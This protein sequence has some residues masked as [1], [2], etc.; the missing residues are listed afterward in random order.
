MTKLFVV[1]VHG[2]NTPEY[3]MY[4]TDVKTGLERGFKAAGA[5]W[6][7]RVE[8]APWPSENGGDALHRIRTDFATCKSGTKP[9]TDRELAL[10]G[11]IQDA[12]KKKHADEHAIVLCHSMGGIL[13][14]SRYEDFVLDAPL[15][16]CGSQVFS[17]G[18]G[19]VFGP[20][21]VTWQVIA[22][23]D[24]HADSRMGLVRARAKCGQRRVL[25]IRSESDE[26]STPY[27]TLTSDKR[28]AWGVH[29]QKVVVEDVGDGYE[30]HSPLR[31]LSTKEAGESIASFVQAMYPGKFPAPA[32]AVA[33]SPPAD[34]YYLSFRE[35][36]F[37]GRVKPN[38]TLFRRKGDFGLEPVRRDTLKGKKRLVF[39]VHGYA[40]SQD[41]AVV[42]W[43]RYADL[44]A[45][46]PKLSG[47]TF[48]P[49]LW[50]G[51]AA[52]LGPLSYPLEE[53]D[54]LTTAKEF[55]W[56]LSQDGT[57]IA[58]DYIDPN[59]RIDIVAMSLG[60][61]VTCWAL[62]NLVRERNRKL[63]NG[64]GACALLAAA[65]DQTSLANPWAFKRASDAVSKLYVAHSTGDVALRAVRPIGDVLSAVLNT[66]DGLLTG[67]DRDWLK[68]Q[69]IE[70][71]LGRN[72]PKDF[73]TST[74]DRTRI[75]VDDW[76]PF[77]HS[78]YEPP[79][80]PGVELRERHKES[81]R[82]V[83]GWL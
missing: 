77:D 11:R 9:R 2:V 79:T 15:V 73:N 69:A 41:E 36:S 70:E 57:G 80:R 75:V 21:G 71:A 7:V 31:V 63:G 26:I 44:L 58:E 33:S 62:D 12:L 64:T 53:E 39:L 48:V 54:A 66:A 60:A 51:D 3:T 27:K 78:D 81:A 30:S 22:F 59:A 38:G 5:D 65:I 47:A 10:L 6:S 49:V 28:L 42:R 20:R 14:A 56:F 29:A 55:A 76:S 32:V 50:P 24:L 25:D 8:P 19:D 52:G 23:S 43:T 4:F 35:Q 82:N 34:V 37:G 83:A 1:A 17:E 18:E 74:W 67:A 45:A 72:G 40:N 13:A 68:S 46:D 61:Y 16:L